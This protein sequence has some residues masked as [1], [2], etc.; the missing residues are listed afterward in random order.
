MRDGPARAWRVVGTGLSF[1]V[2]GIGGVLLWLV[3]FPLLSLAVRD[4]ARRSWVAR[5]W[6]NRSFGAF[7]RLMRALG[8]LT[9]EVRGGERLQRSGLLV[10]A[11]HPTLIDVVFLVSLI[12][13]ADCVVKSRLARNPAMR[14]PINATGYVSNAEGAG[15]IEDCV[16]SV[17]AGSNLVIFPEGTRSPRSGGLNALQRGAANIAVRGGFDITP[18]LIRCEP[19]TLGKGEKWYR[20]PSRRFHILIDVRPDLRVAPFLAGTPEPLAARKLTDHLTDYFHT[21]LARARA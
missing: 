7:M 3:A 2:F 1:A 21:E 20:V 16:A 4:P 19:A 5:R 15:L 6:V 13:N 18:V 11:N 14:G 9:F 10:L 17:R 12:E 8:V